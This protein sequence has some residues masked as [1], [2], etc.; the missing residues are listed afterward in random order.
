M[1]L[2]VLFCQKK[3]K[4]VFVKKKKKKK[5]KNQK[6]APWTL[7]INFKK[8]QKFNYLFIQHMHVHSYPKSKPMRLWHII[9]YNEIVR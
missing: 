9:S 8:F 2:E 7:V 6:K 3:K 5:K 1:K 4:Y